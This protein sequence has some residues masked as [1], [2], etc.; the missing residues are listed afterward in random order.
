MN[1][2]SSIN[3]GFVFYLYINYITHLKI[4]SYNYQLQCSFLYLINEEV[5]LLLIL[6]D[7]LHF[8]LYDILFLF[9]NN[10]YE[11]YIYTI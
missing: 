1:I 8:Y 4:T 3:F 11:L 2:H 9:Y 10:K 7:L 6:F 5:I